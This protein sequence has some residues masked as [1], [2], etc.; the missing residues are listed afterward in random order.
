MVTEAV[1]E[2][3]SPTYDGALPFCAPGAGARRNFN[4]A[5]DLRAVWEYVCRDV[6]DARFVC[7]V[8]SGGSARCLA[9]AD[10]PAG[11]VCGAAEPAPPPEEGL[12]RACTDFVLGTPGVANEQPKYGDLVARAVTACVGD[13]APTA[14]Q[15]ARKDLF[16]R[17]TGLPESF[18]GTDMFFASVGLAEVVH[19]RTREHHPWGNI[20]VDYAPPG[21]TPDEQG[22]L[23]RGVPRAEADAPAVKY[24]QRFFE[25]QGH[26]VAKVLTLHA[27][28]DGL[29]IP[30]NEEKYREVFVATAHADQLVQL[31]TDTG[32][33]CGFSG[34]EHLA[35]F[36]A[37][38]S[39]VEMGKPPTAA[40]AQSM[41][42]A[43]APL[44]GGPCRIMTATPGEW[45]LRV[46]E[47]RQ[48]GAPLHDL[49]CVGDAGDCPA[50]TKCLPSR[51][52]CR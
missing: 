35:A 44:A 13:A 48:P 32:G 40:G 31:F 50:G 24:M 49:V 19:R 38:T 17:A 3:A 45:G 28:D 21:L 43:L 11:Q 16:L 14:E 15:A 39:W 27:L 41:C 2:R 26:T 9:D 12:T 37:L 10:C 51:N 1:L 42:Q 20:G 47:R 22:A 29:V 5:F 25:P 52:Y 46:V 30:E 23:N 8:C 6:P 34:A 18:I 7:H 36:L 4:G 33:H